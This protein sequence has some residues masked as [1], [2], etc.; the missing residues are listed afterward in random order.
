MR[1][2]IVEVSASL[3][4]R[5]GPDALSVR[6]VAEEAGTTT[7]AIYTLFGGKAGLIEALYLEGWERLYRALEAVEESGDLLDYIARL[8]DAYRACAYANP[9]FYELMFGKPVPGFDPPPRTRREARSG[10]R[11]LRDTVLRAIDTGCLAGDADEICHLLWVGAHGF[12]DLHLHGI[13][14]AD[15][16]DALANKHNYAIFE[17]YRPRHQGGS[18][19]TGVPRQAQRSPH[20]LTPMTTKET[21]H[22]APQ[23]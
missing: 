4:H 1:S 10:F 9:H 20:D 15:D 19:M 12:V 13:A 11:L 17:S 8:G 16:E 21:D 22:A 18:Q 5:E 14:Q 3:L 2:R 6:R 7:Q 23:R